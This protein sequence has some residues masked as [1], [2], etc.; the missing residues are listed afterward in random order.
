MKQQFK[1]QTSDIDGFSLINLPQNW[2]FLGSVF[3]GEYE[4][5]FYKFIFA[6]IHNEIIG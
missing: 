2:R 6:D 4:Y 1:R 3:F 5:L